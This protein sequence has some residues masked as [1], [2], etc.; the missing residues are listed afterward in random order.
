MDG[1]A[2]HTGDPGGQGKIKGTPLL[3]AVGIVYGFA[4]L[5]M[6]LVEWAWRKVHPVYV[7]GLIV[8]AVVFIRV[9]LMES[10]AWLRIGRAIMR[11]F[12]ASA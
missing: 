4:V 8:M 6:G 3:G 11:V 12:A 5:V 7:A 10:E 9:F 1:A 2:R